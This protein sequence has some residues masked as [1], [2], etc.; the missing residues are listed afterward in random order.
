VLLGHGF[1]L[2]EIEVGHGNELA[3]GTITGSFDV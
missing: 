1:A 3:I 2:V